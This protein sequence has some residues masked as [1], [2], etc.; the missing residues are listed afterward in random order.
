MAAFP[1]PGFT[2]SPLVRID[3]ERDNQPYF[4]AA[5]ASPG[6]RL[7]RLEGLSPV[8]ETDGGLSWGSLAEA[9]PDH[10]LALLG[11]IDDKPRF[12]SLA[13]PQ[14][15]GPD[16][17]L[18]MIQRCSEMPPGDAGTYA[19]ARSLVNWH[20]RHRF[21]ANCGRIT[22]IRRSGWARFCLR[23]EGGCGTEHFPR[24]DPVVIM[25]AE[26]RDKVL[27]GRNRQVMQGKFYSALAGFLEV[28]ES[29][30]DAVARELFEEAGVVVTSVRYI[31]SQPWPLPSQLMI[32]CIA[33]VESDAITLDSNEL[34]DA[35][36]CDRDEVRAALAGADHARFHMRYPLAIAYT[37]L[38]AW[39]N[40]A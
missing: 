3:I 10:P 20:N 39:V 24:T 25:L 31:T 36:W 1:A 7:L 29:I 27:V 23:E 2:G 35:I 16:P 14:A 15:G 11:L 32:G 4:D 37:L 33:K 22:T 18:A 30:E 9:D 5:V 6:A 38:T 8:V 12:V 13:P 28:G 17:R 26:Y 34:D 19:A 40:G 21:C